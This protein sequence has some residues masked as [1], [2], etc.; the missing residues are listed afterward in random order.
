MPAAQVGLRDL[1]YSILNTD[2]AGVSTTYQAPVKISPAINAKVTPKS[3]NTVLYGDDGATDLA[4][5]V[6][7]IEVEIETKDLPLA[8]QAALLGH[9]L[10]GGVLLRKS[11]DNAPFIALGFRSVKSNGKYRYYWLLKGKAIVPDEDFKTKEDKVAFNTPKLKL[12]FVKRDYDDAYQK[13]ADEEDPNYTS[14]VGT[15][16]FTAVETIDSI[17]PTISS[18]SPANNATA[19]VVGSTV[20]WTF[21]EA[22][23]PS[24]V[25][26]ANFAV[27]KDSDGSNVAGT[28]AIN[29]AN[30]I[31]TFTP[32]ANLTAATAYRSIVTTGVK[33]MAGNA[34][35]APSVTKFTTA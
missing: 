26:A 1:Y 28:L 27:V 35:A 10:N 4:T 16:W 17:A 3:S 20:S 8:V 22:I 24:L 6:G 15:N 34:L 33:D 9:S 13:I 23:Q 2:T 14:S 25:N 31:V 19:V 5:A 21:S 30:T 11:T 29:A 32:S 12:V 7:E 18:V